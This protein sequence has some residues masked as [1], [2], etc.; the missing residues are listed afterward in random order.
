M[1]STQIRDCQRWDLSPARLAPETIP[2]RLHH[3]ASAVSLVHPHSTL[4][5]GLQRGS[6]RKG[7]ITLATSDPVL[8]GAPSTS[9]WRFRHP[10]HTQSCQFSALDHSPCLEWT[11]KGWSLA[12]F[13][14]CPGSWYYCGREGLLPC[15]GPRSLGSPQVSFPKAGV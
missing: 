15:P 1:K 11:D 2:F 4:P 3:A 7:E 8:C 9:D 12:A 14:A 5:L 10:P 6:K 13:T